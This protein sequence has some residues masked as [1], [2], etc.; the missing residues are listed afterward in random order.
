MV[1]GSDH[2]PLIPLYNN[3]RKQAPARIENHRLKLQQYRMAV[4]YEM[5]STN[6][7]DYNSRHPLP[8]TEQQKV[9]ADEETFHINAI[10]DNN[11]PDVMTLNMVRKETNADDR[12]ARLKYCILEKGY[13]PKTAT[14]LQPF[15]QIFEELSVARQVI[16]C[17]E[18]LVIPES[19]Q[20]DVI[21]L[22]HEGH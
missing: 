3:P 12:L 18:R 4:K 20:P 21:A 15:R 9:R 10:I 19:L 22:A 17:G 6:P 5:G 11:I 14:D 13:I 16:L 1:C 2:K 8:I 7:T